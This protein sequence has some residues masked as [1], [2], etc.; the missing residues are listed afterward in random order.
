VKDSA[1]LNSFPVIEIALSRATGHREV[2]DFLLGQLVLLG[3]IQAVMVTALTL[4]IHHREQLGTTAIG[5]GIAMPHC[6]MGILSSVVGIIGESVVGIP[7]PD[8]PDRQPVYR[9]CLFM[10]PNRSPGLHP[11]TLERFVRQSRDG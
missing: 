7:W 10:L 5:S 1:E 9:V 8:S 3:S 11:R 6:E 2:I 4:Q